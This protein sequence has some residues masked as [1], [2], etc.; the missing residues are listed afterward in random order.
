MK[1]KRK[2]KKIDKRYNFGFFVFV[3]L[4]FGLIVLG[5]ATAVLGYT[6][7]GDSFYF[8]K[9]QLTQGILPG[10]LFLFIFSKIK[11]NDWE[12]YSKF[13][14]GFI[15]MLLIL[16]FIPG[17]GVNLNGANS[18]INIAGFSFQPSEIVKLLFL[19]FLAAKIST[20]REEIE[21]GSF[22]KSFLPFLFY[23]FFVIGLIVAQPDFGTATV[24]F[25]YSV[26]IYFVGGGKIRH[27]TGLFLGAG[28]FLFLMV[29]KAPYRMNRLLAF[30]HPEND[31]LDVGYHIKQSLIAVGSGGFLGLGYGNS[32]QKFQYLPEV[33]SDSVFAVMSEEL[34]FLMVFIFLVFY[35]LFIYKILDFSKKTDNQ[36]VKLF[37]VGFATW[38]G[39]QGIINIGA[40]IGILPIT[41]VPLPF[42]S[43][44]GTA[45]VSLLSGVGVLI[46]MK[47]SVTNKK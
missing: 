42:I 37:S 43:H 1:Q 4:F 39:V 21:T 9:K 38:I 19:I 33:Q 31:P 35:F 40:V 5:S 29:K 17:I 7:T 16:V 26:A 3:L 14:F 46:G 6:Q 15:L 2:E 25:A 13:I 41:G 36:F 27:L 18:W 44:G 20:N 28:A 11:Y 12:K 32:R 8:L 45:M 10:L 47:K 30:L 23:I 22:Q 34:G 24:I